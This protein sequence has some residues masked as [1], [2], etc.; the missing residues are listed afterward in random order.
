MSPGDKEKIKQEL[1]QNTGL[2]VDAPKM[3]EIPDEVDNTP[4]GKVKAIMRRFE[5][6]MQ[7][8]FNRHLLH[9]NKQIDGMHSA[10]FSQLDKKY[11]GMYKTLIHTFLT[12]IESKIYNSEVTIEAIK[13]LMKEE[14][15]ALHIENANTADIIRHLLP[16]DEHLKAIKDWAITETLTPEEYTNLFNEKISAQRQLVHDEI[17]KARSPEI[18][19]DKKDES[20]KET[21]P[22]SEDSEGSNNPENDKGEVSDSTD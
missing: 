1:K 3:D 16:E 13:G 11:G 7:G 2:E 14:L 20:T 9:I 21:K 12:N 4:K 15:H 17:E 18:N 10:L 22:S 8:Q 5:A 19:K 6:K